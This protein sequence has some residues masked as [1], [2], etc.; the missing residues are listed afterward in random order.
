M[1]RRLVA[2]VALGAAAIA[3]I[4]FV[5]SYAAVRRLAEA[6][7]FGAFAMI[8]PVGV[9]A[10]ILVLLA[11]DLLLTWLRMPFAMLRQTA[12][13]LTSATIAFNGAAAWPDPIG[14]G[15]HAVIPVL[16]VVV[17][18]AA[19]HAI[20]V[21]A[22]ISAA[23]HMESVRLSRWL[24]APVGTFR[25]WRRMKLWELRSYAEVIALEQERLIERARLRRRYGRKWR[26][27]APVGAVL[28]L[29][30]TRYG[31][32]LA[33]VEGV[34]DTAPAPVPAP[35]S[36]APLDERGAPKRLA[37]QGAPTLPA[38]PP[39]APSEGAPTRPAPVS[40]GAPAEPAPQNEGAPHGDAPDDQG[41]PQ[42]D[43][44]GEQSAPDEPAPDTEGAPQRP[45]DETAAPRDEQRPPTRD[46][47]KRRIRA[48]YEDL[49][50]RPGEGV[51]VKLLESLDGYPHKSRR[52]AQ[53][54]R[55][56]IEAADPKLLERVSPNI[57]AMT[58]T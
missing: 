38:P 17:V 19:R 40:E 11:L 50:D 22:D 34:L 23:K 12:W 3:V 1:Q 10:G 56:E 33:P 37:L 57:R 32:P 6:K 20:G 55:G 15:M 46:E 54:L 42:A 2:G 31:R 58:G 44:G 4:G 36:E 29:R 30:L 39:A 45:A 48:L 21:A 53:K 28:A 16:F 49:D 47:V 13:L 18:E 27:K 5:G 14:T 51:I 7:H 41:A 25:L 26:S 9:D 24:L 52:H 35:A 8:F 43:E